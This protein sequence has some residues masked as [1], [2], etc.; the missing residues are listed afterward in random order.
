VQVPGVQ[1]LAAWL[2]EWKPELLAPTPANCCSMSCE[3]FSFYSK[4]YLCLKVGNEND[5]DDDQG[6]ILANSQKAH[7]NKFSSL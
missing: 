5:D 4:Q 7:R 2:V 1:E 3:N 6:S